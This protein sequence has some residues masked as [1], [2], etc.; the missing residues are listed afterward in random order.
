[1]DARSRQADERGDV[2]IRHGTKLKRT[3]CEAKSKERPYQRNSASIV[4]LISAY[5]ATRL[6]ICHRATIREETDTN[7]LTRE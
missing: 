7:S 4:T 1:M 2:F 5:S 3:G 6:I